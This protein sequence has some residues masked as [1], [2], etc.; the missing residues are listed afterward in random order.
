MPSDFSLCPVFL[1]TNCREGLS[2]LFWL[3]K[4]GIFSANA[5]PT[6]SQAQV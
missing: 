2:M 3:Q 4:T 6:L 5:I 1:L